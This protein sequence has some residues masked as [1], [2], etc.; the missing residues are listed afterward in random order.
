MIEYFTTIPSSHR[1]IILAFSLVFCW[2]LE[3][4]IPLFNFQYNKYKHASV[5]LFFTLTTILINLTFATILLLAAEWT[6]QNKIGI[7]YLMDLPIWLHA[8]FAIMLMD[9]IG[10]YW[11]H[12]LMHTFSF[13]WKLHRIHHIDTKVDATTALRAHPA[14]SIL[15]AIFLLFGILIA[16]AEIWM[17]MLYQSISVLN[18]QIEHANIKFPKWFDNFLEIFIVS[19]DMHK[20]HHSRK[21]IET[22]S[23]FANIFSIWD[24]I[25]GSYRKVEDTESI[26]YGLAEFR[27]EKDDTI[28]SLLK[29]PFRK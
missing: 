21:Q 12:R 9:M 8:I 28:T 27:T 19:P 22:D 3:G 1:T 11:I 10:A 7:L 2:A 17:V 29:N 5:N 16:G 20:V 6:V 26:E 13:G 15:R 25:F 24:R 4:A 14:E 18:A 23:N